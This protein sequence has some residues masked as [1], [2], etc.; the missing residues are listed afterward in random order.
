MK[1]KNEK[2]PEWPKIACAMLASESPYPDVEVDCLP[3]D[4]ETT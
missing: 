2:V 1:S 4:L 3:F